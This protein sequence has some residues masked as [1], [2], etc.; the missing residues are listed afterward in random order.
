[1]RDVVMASVYDC[2][3]PLILVDLSCLQ[4]QLDKI[5]HLD[6]Q[7]TQDNTILLNGLLSIVNN[8]NFV[9]NNLD[10]LSQQTFLEVNEDY[11]EFNKKL[12][13]NK[14]L[15]LNANL[16][17]IQELSLSLLDSFIKNNLYN[18]TGSLLVSCLDAS[19]LNSTVVKKGKPECQLVQTL[20]TTQFSM[21][22]Q[23]PYHYLKQILILS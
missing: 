9:I 8:K 22:S 20:S 17:I 10:S 19:I 11:R 14:L 21:I 5:I 4:E 7:Y 12:L 1:M 3:Q 6:F 23:H 18:T 13:R 2:E 15:R 16:E